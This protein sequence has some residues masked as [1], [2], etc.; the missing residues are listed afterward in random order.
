MSYFIRFVLLACLFFISS[1]LAA[2]DPPLVITPIGDD[3]YLYETYNTYK[4]KI[5]SANGMYM[6]TSQG[7]VM[8]DSPWDKSQFQPLLD[9]IWSRHQQPVVMCLATHYHE[10]RTAGLS[11]YG[12]RGIKTYT[13]SLTDSLSRANGYELAEYLIEEDTTFQI[14]DLAFSTHFLGHGHSPDNIVVWIDSLKILYGGCLIKSAEANNLGYL[15]VADIHEWKKTMERVKATFK[16]LNWVIPGHDG[17]RDISS[18]DQTYQLLLKKIQQESSNK[19][20]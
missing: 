12:E 9:S 8:I 14:G 6:V 2:S 18:I 17:W 4:G 16:D 13:T 5:Y 10:D 20:E 19:G 15:G 3:V 11:Y 7:V 1:L